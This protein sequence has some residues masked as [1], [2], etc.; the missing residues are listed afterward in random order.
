[1]SE[2]YV[3]L[4]ILK[5]RIARWWYLLRKRLKYVEVTVRA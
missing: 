4:A 5:A 1:M 2:Q 3:W